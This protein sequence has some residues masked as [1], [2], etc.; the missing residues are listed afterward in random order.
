MT[1]GT[2]VRW[3]VSR[4]NPQGYPSIDPQADAA[5]V[6]TVAKNTF[7]IHAVGSGANCP[8]CKGN[9][10]YET[11]TPWTSAEYHAMRDGRRI[12]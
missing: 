4:G 11:V 1:S 2:C 5:T 8:T 12:A 7:V 3:Y 9:P 6:N 10:G